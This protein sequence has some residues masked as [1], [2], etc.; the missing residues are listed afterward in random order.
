MLLVHSSIIVHWYLLHHRPFLFFSFVLLPIFPFSPVLSLTTFPHPFTSFC[1]PS[2]TF[3]L[4][5]FPS[6]CFVSCLFYYIHFPSQ[7][8]SSLLFAN[9][10]F[11]SLPFSSLPFLFNSYRSPLIPF[12]PPSL[13]SPLFFPS[14]WFH[15]LS[16]PLLPSL[17]LS[18][19]FLSFPFLPSPSLS[20][21]L[22]PSPSLPIHS[23]S[24]PLL[25][26]P[27]LQFTCQLTFNRPLAYSYCRFTHLINLPLL[28]FL[29]S[30]TSPSW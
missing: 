8:S 1:P 9:L 18:I 29:G 14:C 2:L 28:V 15:F 30:R 10:P 17:S 16:F 11:L 13:P 26:S 4:C 12:P 24:F 23:L 19:H 5:P 25:S 22:L 21:S 6:F 27:T 7:L 20:F 3:H